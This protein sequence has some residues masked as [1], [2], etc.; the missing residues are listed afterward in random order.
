MG[1]STYDSA[2][3]QMRKPS[4]FGNC[5]LL[6][7]NIPFQSPR[8]AS[9]VQYCRKRHNGAVCTRCSR[10]RP[11]RR[12]TEITS[13]FLSLRHPAT[14]DY[15][16]RQLTFRRIHWSCQ[17]QNNC[18]RFYSPSA[19]TKFLVVKI[20]YPSSVDEERQ[21]RLFKET[22]SLPV[23]RF[24]IAL[25]VLAEHEADVLSN[26]GLLCPLRSLNLYPQRKGTRMTTDVMYY[27]KMSDNFLLYNTLGR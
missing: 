14:L 6:G 5:R 23:T 18:T 3:L 12:D 21:P 24:V 19:T 7:Y 9:T 22:R 11:G 25:L 26:L 27:G 4:I 2:C 8:V 17:Q 16:F 15:S 1:D 10:R 13:A 20:I